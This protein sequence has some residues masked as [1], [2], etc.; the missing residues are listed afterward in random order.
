MVWFETSFL[1]NRSEMWTRLQDS[2]L[3][4]W[5]DYEPMER[6]REAWE[7]AEPLGALHH[8]IRAQH[9]ARCTETT[10]KRKHD[11]ALNFWLRRVLECMCERQR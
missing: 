8:A 3:A 6:L 4:L 5:T 9:L 11:G 10:S 1:M 7:L 2:Y